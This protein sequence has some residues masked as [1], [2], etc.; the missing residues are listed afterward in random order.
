MK[1][2][3]WKSGLTQPA[4]P[5]QS[6]SQVPTRQEQKQPC[7]GSGKRSDCLR[8]R[9]RQSSQKELSR[10]EWRQS[11]SSRR[12]WSQRGGSVPFP[13]PLLRQTGWFR[14]RSLSP[15]KDQFWCTRRQCRAG[16]NIAGS[17]LS[18]RLPSLRYPR[19]RNKLLAFANFSSRKEV[20]APRLSFQRFWVRRRACVSDRFP[21][22]HRVCRTSGSASGEA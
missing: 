10:R 18:T 7:V 20:C 8:R 12:E 5:S 22:E 19:C 21:H 3:S 6:R 4:N 16:R 9:H 11:G 1:S 17:T 15:R 13:C 2:A 14:H